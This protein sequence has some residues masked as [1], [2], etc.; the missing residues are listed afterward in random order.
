[1]NLT[2]N[3]EL[4][5]RINLNRNNQIATIKEVLAVLKS[6]GLVVFPSD[7]V[8][9]LLADAI[10]PKAVTRLLEFKERKPGQAISVFV[11]DKKMSNEYVEINQN[12]NNVINN[13]LPGP[14]TIVC[15]SKQSYKASKLQRSKE[16]QE[17]D[18]RLLAENGTLGI[19][20]PDYPLI[21]QLLTAYGLPL[22]ATSANLSGRP[23]HYSISS[24]LKSLS[25]KKKSA[26][27]LIVD[28][29]NLPKNKPSTVIDTT[30]G[31]L[32]TLRIGDLLPKTA[33]SLISKSE[34]ETKHL[35]RFLATKFIKKSFSRP[36]VFLLEGPLGA[37]KTIFAKGLAKALKIKEEIVSPTYVIGYEYKITDPKVITLLTPVDKLST[38][39]PIENS[40]QFD[41][42]RQ[43][44]NI[45]KVGQ[46]LFPCHS[47]QLNPPAGGEERDQESI[48]M[49]KYIDS[50]L[51]R[52]DNERPPRPP[53]L[54]H[55]DL[56]RIESKEELKEINF[57]SGFSC[58]NIYLIEWA[59]RLPAEII[60]ALKKL[61][62][63]VYIKIKYLGEKERE[64]EWGN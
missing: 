2:L 15:K 8:Y 30:T 63:I 22:T 57:L 11:A 20:I 43:N 39:S 33:N 58:G 4:M 19:R 13:L 21:I 28:A 16:R 56:F 14:F 3:F 46:V 26:L 50:D 6:G 47:G 48:K 64:I 12:A 41:I 36:L 44:L 45:N 10:N 38:T 40:R 25:K 17:I 61:A 62:E 42:E 5:R 49:K 51:H 59:E 27:N 53:L 55:Y 60:S 31:Q 35:A 34:D 7:T 23:P 24:L 52:N 32:K 37:G 9:G 29:G 18:K 1:M 54:I